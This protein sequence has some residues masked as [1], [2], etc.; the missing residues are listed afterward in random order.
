MSFEFDYDEE[1]KNREVKS[2]DE[3]LTEGSLARKENIT[4]KSS[5]EK[6]AKKLSASESN[7]SDIYSADPVDS[8]ALKERT[9]S[10]VVEYT[11]PSIELN[12]ESVPSVTEQHRNNDASEPI[13]YH[14]NQKQLNVELSFP[15][16][17]SY[18]MFSEKQ[19]R[20]IK[21]MK[22]TMSKKFPTYNDFIL[23]INSYQS[24]Y[25]MDARCFLFYHIVYTLDNP[26]DFIHL[27]DFYP[28]N[29]SPIMAGPYYEIMDFWKHILNYS[30][31]K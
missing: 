29:S 2:I 5:D 16:V 19:I 11:A 15:P 9:G 4:E 12:A 31:V 17:H 1:L 3:M 7:E 18:N 10:S 27:L 23:C 8:V 25:S 28:F 24:D 30:I 14:V 22:H 13:I 21:K 6:Y 20:F 26:K